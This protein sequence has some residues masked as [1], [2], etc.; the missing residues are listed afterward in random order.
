MSASEGL[1]CQER[2]RRGYANEGAVPHHK[3]ILHC[4]GRTEVHGN[5]FCGIGRS[6]QNLPVE[7]SRP[8]VIGR[9]LVGAGDEV[10]A[11]RAGNRRAHDSPC[12]FSGESGDEVPILD[13]ELDAFR[14]RA[15][16]R[17]SGDG[18]GQTKPGHPGGAD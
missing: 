15:E 12:L 13:P 8:C 17:E 10:A 18:D 16:I 9:I 2:S 11:V 4:F 7:H 14:T 5:Q 3:D 6:A 1:I